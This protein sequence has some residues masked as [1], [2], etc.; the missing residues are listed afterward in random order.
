MKVIITNVDLDL[1][2]P[3]PRMT[4]VPTFQQHGFAKLRLKRI[5]GEKYEFSGGERFKNAASRSKKILLRVVLRL[6]SLFKIFCRFLALF[7]LDLHAKE[8]DF[9]IKF[10]KITRNE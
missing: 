4:D 6:K 3:E 2:M 9:Q 7:R 10:M 5:Y 8:Y 1:A